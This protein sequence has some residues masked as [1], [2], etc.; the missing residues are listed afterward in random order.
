M[1]EDLAHMISPTPRLRVLLLAY[2][3]NPANPSEP[4]VSYEWARHL[5]RRVELTVVT[6]ER[7]QDAIRRDGRL[8]CRMLYVP[9]ERFSRPLWL[10]N[11]FLF[12]DTHVPSK[13]VLGFCD[14][15]CY[16]ALASNCMSSRRSN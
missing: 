14:Y 2:H 8:A 9:A 15:L 11:T 10:S 5:Q 4:R 1:T 3:C 12:G 16:E 6:H 7:N 13:M